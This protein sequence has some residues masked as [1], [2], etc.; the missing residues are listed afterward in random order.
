MTFGLTPAGWNPKTAADLQAEIEADQRAAPAL[1]ADLYTGAEA[2]V[3]GLNA[4][5]IVQLTALW[6]LGTALH[7]ALSRDGSAGAQLNALGALTGSV[8]RGKTK[9]KV[10]LTL[11]VA[12]GYAIPVGVVAFVPAAPTN[13]WVTL[14]AADNTDGTHPTI[15]VRAEAQAAGRTPANAGQ[16]TGIA[17]PTPGWVAVTNALDAAAGDDDEADPPYRVRQEAELSRPG[18]SPVPALRAELLDLADADGEPLLVACVVKENPSSFPDNDGRPPHSVEAIVQFAPGLS[19]DALAAA[20]LAV[21]EAIFAG[22]AGGADTYGDQ[23]ASVLDPEG[24]PVEVFFNEPTAVDIYVEIDLDVDP[25]TYVGDAAVQDA[26]TAYG[27]A[28][29]MGDDVVRAALIR[30][31]MGLGGVRDVT[32][33]E[34]GVSSGALQPANVPIDARAL[35]VFDT[36]RVAVAT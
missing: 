25:D 33:L 20:R 8:R 16:I 21:A 17:T 36:S 14:E 12:N 31:A 6:E 24:D 23:V 27:D 7:N 4:V 28:R 2:L 11:S 26:V 32:R 22:K 9:G 13:R 30:V 35:A 3:G 18:S 29:T 15:A 34:L 19:G 5:M 10:V 1:G